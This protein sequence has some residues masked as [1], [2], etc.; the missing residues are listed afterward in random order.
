MTEPIVPVEPGGEIDWWWQQVVSTSRA[1]S[2]V[3]VDADPDDA[4]KVAETLGLGLVP[5]ADIDHHGLASF[6]V[7]PGAVGPGALRG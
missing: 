3:N 7:H 6:T 5:L 2:A 1:E 4:A